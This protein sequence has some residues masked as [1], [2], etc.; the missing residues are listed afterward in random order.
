[1][2]FSIYY[3]K[4]S[5]LDINI[6]KEYLMADSKFRVRKDI[7]ALTPA[8]RKGFF[9]TL[10]LLG[11]LLPPQGSGFETWKFDTM[12]ANG[13]TPVCLHDVLISNHATACE[14]N[15][16]YFPFYHRHLMILTEIF[17]NLAH[18]ILNG[19]TPKLKEVY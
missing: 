13:Y 14:H 12:M 7:N 15:S 10:K 18:Q 6:L 11:V 4:S 8:E 9:I 2:F 5:C 16:F 3:E 19:G 17:L 1:M